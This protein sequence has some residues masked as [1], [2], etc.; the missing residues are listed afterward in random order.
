MTQCE[1]TLGQWPID[2]V[3]TNTLRKAREASKIESGAV[4]RYVIGIWREL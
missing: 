3:L 2:R 1:A 4:R